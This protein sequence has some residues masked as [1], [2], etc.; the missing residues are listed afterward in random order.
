MPD[1]NLKNAME[2][3]KE[4]LKKHDCGAFVLLAGPA[5]L[6]YL[7]EVSPS[8]SC[9]TLNAEGVLRIKAMREDY[10]DDVS[11][12]LAIEQTVGMFLGFADACQSTVNNMSAIAARLS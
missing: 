10:P 1:Q 2:E 4:V 7:Y 3:I 8:W 12:Q 11:H 5:H 6:E 9:A